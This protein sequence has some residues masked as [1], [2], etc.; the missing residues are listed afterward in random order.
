[1]TTA[2][3][4]SHRKFTAASLRRSSF[5]LFRLRSRSVGPSV[6]TTRSPLINDYLFL[7]GV[8]PRGRR[9]APPSSSTRVQQ[10]QYSIL[11]ADTTCTSL[12]RCGAA[13]AAARAAAAAQRQWRR[14]SGRMPRSVAWR[15]WPTG[16]RIGE[17]ELELEPDAIVVVA[18]C[19]ESKP[20]DWS[21]MC[22]DK[23]QAI[24]SGESQSS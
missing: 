19:H 9:P 20:T 23:P 15:R 10:Q 22:K 3:L 12:A 11:N 21:K 7:L 6:L 17:R 2:V 18:P 16:T 14:H 5:S 13:A 24:P 8:A 4:R 1:M